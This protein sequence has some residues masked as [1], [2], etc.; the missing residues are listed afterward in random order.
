MTRLHKLANSQLPTNSETSAL[1][2][3][4]L[5]TNLCTHHLDFFFFYYLLDLRGGLARLYVFTEKIYYKSKHDLQVT[6][7]QQ[8]N[9][10]EAKVPLLGDKV[11]SGI[12][13]PMVDMLDSTPYFSLD[14]AS[15]QSHLRRYNGQIRVFLRL[16]IQ[17]IV[18]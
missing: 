15:V 7:F 14:S 11:D 5:L 3:G 9:N 2:N 1:A 8:R 10:T 6:N 16:Y 18:K 4:G 17:C 13:L 12:R